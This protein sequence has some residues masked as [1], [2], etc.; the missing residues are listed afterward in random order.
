MKW[1]LIAVLIGV[2]MMIARAVS[3]QYKEKYDFY[4]NLKTF[5][6]QFK[7]NLSFRQ[8][9]ILDFLNKTNAK[10]QFKIFINSYKKYLETNQVDFSEIK[11]LDNEEIN[12]L[13]MIILNIGKLDAKNEINQL[14]TFIVEIDAKLVKAQDDKNKLCP[15]ILKLSLLFAIGLAVILI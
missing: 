5:L 13:K 9:K 15:M 7:L 8:E 12:Q 4:N 10:K 1:V 11:L 14:E 2:I 3:E 6:N